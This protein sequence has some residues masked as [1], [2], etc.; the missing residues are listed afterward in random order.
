MS[1]QPNLPPI[2]GSGN[3]YFVLFN[4][5]GAILKGYD[6]EATAAQSLNPELTLEELMSDAEEITYPVVVSG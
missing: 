3:S 2:D 4:R 5:H 1:S 6:H